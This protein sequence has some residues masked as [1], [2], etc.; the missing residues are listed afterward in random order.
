MSEHTT[1]Y[2]EEE[3]IGNS[4]RAA[5][6]AE[7]LDFIEREKARATAERAAWFK[8]DCSSEKAY[9]TSV[10][11]YRKTFTAMLGLDYF[12][13]F[14]RPDAPAEAMPV[15]EDALSRIFR[16]RIPVLPGLFLYGLLF[17][18][19]EG[20]RPL[21]IV[22]HGGQGTPELCAGFFGS[23]NYNDIVRRFLRKGVHV[24]APQLMLYNTSRFGPEFDRPSMDATLRQLGT[25]VTALHVFELQGAVNWLEAQPFVEG[26]RIGMAG[27]SYGG[28]YTLLTAA[29]DPRIRA[30]YIAGVFNDRLRYNDKMDMTM[31]GQADKLTD[32]E[33]AG[34]I[35]PRPLF[36]EAGCNDEFFDVQ[37]A[38]REAGRAASWYKQ[39]HLDNLFRF[40]AF[41]G[42]HEFCPDDAGVDFLL[43]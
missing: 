22:Q 39:L 26:E 27:L 5:Y 19:G 42:T 30:A 1:L 17:R 28:F 29:A 4:Y 9:S 38:E 32:A 33:I 6:L 7:T 41:D 34:L 37:S 24:F 40:R 20:R 21:V 12:S 35:C 23:E 43:R 25:S 3:Q 14:P 36:I 13:R 18:T 2:T 16:V 31:Q 8:P 11:G 15:A 10:A